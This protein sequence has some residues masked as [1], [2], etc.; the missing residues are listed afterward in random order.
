MSDVFHKSLVE[1]G[2][3][4]VNRFMFPGVDCVTRGAIKVKGKGEMKVSVPKETR[5]R[6]GKKEEERERDRL[7]VCFVVPS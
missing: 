7:C 2:I 6:C 4:N 5:M 3:K 1:Q